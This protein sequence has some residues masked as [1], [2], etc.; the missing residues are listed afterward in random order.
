MK[1]VIREWQISDTKSLTENINNISIWNNMR[2]Y[3]PYPYNEN[4]A[5]DFIKMVLNKSKP[6]VDMAIDINGNAVG[7][8]GIIL[9]EDV[10]RIC[11]EI[12]Y[13]LGE[14][15]WNRGIM[16]EAIKQMTNYAF[17]NFSLH[18]IFA[19]PF[20]FNIASQC[21]LQKAGYKLEAVLKHSAIKNEKIIDL[22][23]YSIIKPVS[24]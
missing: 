14:A 22:H 12:G 4:D 2:D 19:T 20:D 16:S 9:K 23:Y 5:N 6:V 13:W 15:Y 17:N 1:I 21:V 10:E 7:G 18:K 24:Y 11:A 3:L 8:I